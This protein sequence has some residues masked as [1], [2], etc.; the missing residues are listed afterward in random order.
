[1]KQHTKKNHWNF[2]DKMIEKI[3]I[4]KIEIEKLTGKKSGI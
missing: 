1:M 4:F 2:P 3:I